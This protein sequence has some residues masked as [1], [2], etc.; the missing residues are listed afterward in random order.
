[1]HHIDRERLQTFR[2]GNASASEI[3]GEALV[4]LLGGGIDATIIAEKRSRFGAERFGLRP[5]GARDDDLRRRPGPKLRF[6]ETVIVK[7]SARADAAYAL[8]RRHAEHDVIV[9][10]RH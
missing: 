2:L 8:R 5:I 4:D 1:E 6:A 3:P 7:P 10:D 9:L